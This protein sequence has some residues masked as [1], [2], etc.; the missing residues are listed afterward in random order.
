MT[1]RTITLKALVILHVIIL[2]VLAGGY[3]AATGENAGV[4]ARYNM[5][6]VYFGNPASYTSLVDNTD[7]SLD[8][9][10][11]NYF[12]LNEDGT[13]K[14]TPVVDRGFIN[15]MHERGIKVVPFLSNHWDRQKGINALN[16]RE[17]LASQ[18]AEAISEY[19]LDG[20]NVDIE[21][22]TENERD[23]YTD[24]VRL[25]REKLPDGKTVSVAVVPNPYGLTQGWHASYDY[26]GLARYCDYL[27]LMAYD[28]H[29]QGDVSKTGGAGPVAGYPFVEASIKA[30]LREVPAGKL[31]LGIPFYGRLWKRGAAY[32][33]YGI[34]NNTVAELVMEYNGK[35]IYDHVQKSPRA[36][37]TIKASGKKPVVFGNTLE[38]GTYDIWFENE[39][40]IKRKLELVG[41]YGLKGAGSW[42]LGQEEK[43]TWDFYSLWLNGRYFGDIQKHWA[44][45]AIV[46]AV[47]NGWMK[48][49]SSARFLPDAPVTRAQAAAIIV[50][51]L[52]IDTAGF[53]NSSPVFSDTAGHW[54][55]A[56]IEA[57]AAYGLVKGTADGI[58]EP[59]E[60]LTREQMMVL[61]DRIIDVGE[62]PGKIFFS[63][64]TPETAQWAYESINRMAAAGLVSGF[65]DGLFHPKEIMNRGQIATLMVRIYPYIKAGADE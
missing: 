35:V 52:G 56:E 37:V 38:A 59:D 50:R 18:V 12:D 20:V 5:S 8:E 30:A 47:D 65:P 46:A 6:Y 48:G 22:M 3:V 29:Y 63:D 58:F 57:A 45:K 28:E 44:K 11:P 60:A 9:I 54:A 23:I 61:L 1:V 42:S 39:E 53:I 27:L 51:M 14:L 2:L 13:L 17:V 33:G 49:V 31:L 16:N 32:G 41:K 43:S 26:A 36:V 24:F 25:L 64:V 62:P 15:G 34:S 55:F 10:A 40:S 4:S 19:G 7:G 21:N